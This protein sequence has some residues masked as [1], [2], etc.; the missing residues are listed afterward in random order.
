MS[1]LLS[2]YLLISSFQL[3]EAAN[4]IQL[5]YGDSLGELAP[6][7]AEQR[8]TLFAGYPYLYQASV[9]DDLPYAKWFVKLSQ[10]A[11]AIA[12]FN[13]LPVGL[14]TGTSFKDFDE[15]FQGSIALFENAQLNPA[16]YYYVSEVIIMPQHRKYGLSKQ[17]FLILECHAKKLGYRK[18]CFVTESHKEHPLKPDAYKELDGLWKKLGYDTMNLS[19][20]FSWPTLQVDGSCMNQEHVLEY[21]QKDL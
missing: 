3:L 15:H 5:H 1:I 12:Y 9:E 7:I 18:I 2:F 20:Q 21:W 14:I 11:G 13:D 10:S 8:V 16:D 4:N 19:I 17:L 6:F